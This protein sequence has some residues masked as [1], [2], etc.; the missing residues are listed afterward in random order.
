[1]TEL[2]SRRAKQTR[3]AL[4]AMIRL[5]PRVSAVLT[6][7]LAAVL[8]AQVVLSVTFVLATAALIA[9]LA[10]RQPGPA[11][12]GPTG[13]VLVDL[14]IVAASFL[15]R[16]I[17]Q[18]VITAAAAGLG[19]RLT[20]FLTSTTLRGALRPVGIRHLADPAV[21]DQI[22]Q[23]QGVGGSGYPPG[24]AVVSLAAVTSSRLTGL[25]AAV[26]LARIRWWMPLP[27]MAAWMLTGRW[28]SRE[29]RRAVDAQGHATQVLRHAA[30]ARDLAISGTGG[31]EIRV[32]GLET[33]LLDR[34]TA[35]W[36]QG[37]NLLRGSQGWRA[38]AA[39]VV[40]LAGAHAAVLIPLATGAAHG[41]LSVQTATVAV[42]AV[43]GLSSLGW[44]GDQQ[45]ILA[46]ASA[47]VPPA[48]AVGQLTAGEASQ[49]GTQPAAGRPASGIEFER[50]QFGYPD[51]PVL[52]G[53]DLSIPAGTSLALVGVNGA[54]KST[55]IKLLAR[56]YDPVA[57]RIAV[58]G[59]DL[60]DLDP[61]AWRR[62]VAV[63]FQ[64]FVHY[65]LPLRD[66]VGFGR[67]AEA[68]DDGAL[69]RAAGLAR[70]DGVVS[71]L[72]AGWDTPM[73]R[74][75]EGGVDL[76]GGQWQ[77]VALARAL[78]AAEH[79]ARVLVLDEPTAHLDVR[80]EADLY[81]RFLD[82][83]SGLTTI[84]VSHRFATVRLADKICVLDDGRITEY[85][86]HDEL[87]AAAGHYAQMFA[88]QSA[89]FQD[90]GHD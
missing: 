24:Q 69:S 88:L 84:L 50:V 47:T 77:R 86:S 31:K 2:G 53:L 8:A 89:P 25:A 55:I 38:Q 10:A 16:L 1:M 56:L 22:F 28:R 80:A 64:D 76:S 61:L 5:L 9:S 17:T 52:R 13:R 35:A 51:R 20:A 81:E 83:T 48:L 59:T 49:G 58:D 32:F 12:P 45:W 87:V 30:Y 19:R 71:A 75:L 33:W 7:L 37:M 39:G 79:G 21:A 54:G 14:I 62:Q 63:V 34:F 60:R 72:P 40:L 44:I 26:L 57:G 15:L 42:Q 82:I 65:E 36:L 43:V 3:L 90:A 66:N 74:R 23:V 27:L 18:P 67:V 85:G 73:G 68:R 4:L 46:A 70:L 41:Q 29:V 11:Q 6:G 78:F